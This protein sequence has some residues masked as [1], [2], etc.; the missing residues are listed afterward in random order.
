HGTI[1]LA[2][3]AI[4]EGAEQ[5][6]TKPIELQALLLAVD[7]LIENKQNR[8]VRAA[9]ETRGARLFDPLF[10]ESPAIRKLA[11]KARLI[12]PSPIPTLIQG[13]TGSG[14][15]LLAS[16]IHRNGPRAEE[17]FVDLNCAG[18]SREFLESE[19]FGH[20]RG[21]FTGA[22][23]TKRGLLEVAHRGNFFL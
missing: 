11:E 10:G 3:R 18:L 8:E 23:A 7:R 17:P 19:L 21:A 22:V 5:F 2:V 1:D 16:W 20:E 9:N 14:K 6:L 13:E 4:K 12:L 15:G